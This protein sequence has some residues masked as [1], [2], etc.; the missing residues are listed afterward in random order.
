MEV[1]NINTTQVINHLL[2]K[3]KEIEGFT[4]YDKNGQKAILL[5]ALCKNVIIAEI[6][7]MV[8]FMIETNSKG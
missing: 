7:E 4:N 6:K 8:N 2:E 1:L 3:C 5:T